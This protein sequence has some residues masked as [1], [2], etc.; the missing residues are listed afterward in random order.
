MSSMP[1]E[2]ATTGDNRANE[3]IS[4]ASTGVMES[5][6]YQDGESH[7][8]GLYY[9]RWLR[10]QLNMPPLESVE[11]EIDQ[12]EESVIVAVFDNRDVETVDDE[13]SAPDA[14][15]YVPVSDEVSLSSSEK[16]A[17]GEMPSAVDDY[18]HIDQSMDGDDDA[19]VSII[20]KSNGPYFSPIALNPS[21]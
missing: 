8:N 1:E 13:I 2:M 19:P 18:E 10:S 12:F 4:V 5:S 15:V 7:M 20:D 16:P 14:E 21:K 11:D 9:L 17:A 3:E 6:D